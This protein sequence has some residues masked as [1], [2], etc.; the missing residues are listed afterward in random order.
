MHGPW[1][2]N[3]PI[4]VEIVMSRQ[5][6]NS[7]IVVRWRRLLNANIGCPL[8]DE[9]QIVVAGGQIIRAVRV[10]NGLAGA[11][12]SAT[13]ATLVLLGIAAQHHVT[14]NGHALAIHTDIQIL[15]IAACTINHLVLLTIVETLA[16]GHAV[17]LAGIGSIDV[18]HPLVEQ[19][20][21]LGVIEA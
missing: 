8:R 14:A 13:L 1:E 20:I 18:W 9:Q 5:V 10:L 4:A 12:I 11:A 15:F 17:Q 16:F 2:V 7:Q 19:A 6:A 21:E 3:A